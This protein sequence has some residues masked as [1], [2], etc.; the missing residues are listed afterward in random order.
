[1]RFV[2]RP[3]FVLILL[4]VPVCACA[5]SWSGVLDPS[6]AI[7]WSTIGAGPIPSGSWTQCG[8]TIAA[9]GSVVSPQSTSTIN[10]AIT[11]CGANHYVLLGPGTFYL[12]DK[13]VMGANNVVLRGSGPDKTV[14]RFYGGGSCWIATTLVC[15]NG[16]TS[17]D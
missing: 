2:R 3:L 15:F 7:D 8:A 4:F 1:M 11:S 12:S 13:L 5:Q 14:L 17:M 9:Y 16:G 6:R 10:N